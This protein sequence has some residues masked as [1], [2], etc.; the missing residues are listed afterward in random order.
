[1]LGKRIDATI[2]IVTATVGSK[3]FFYFVLALTALQGLWFALSFRPILFDEGHHINFIF[4]YRD[5][6]LPIISGQSTEWDYLGDVTRNSSYL[7]Y[8]VMSL[9]L[10]ALFFMED[11]HA[12]QII[13][14]RV[15]SLSLFLAS[16][17]LFRSALLKAGSSAASTHTALLVFV[18]IPAIAPM[19]GVVSYDVAM[20]ALF[21]LQVLWAIEIIKSGRFELA[22]LTGL[23]VLSGL[24]TVIKAA[25]IPLSIAILL[26]IIWFYLKRYGGA[27]KREF[28]DAARAMSAKF[29]ILLVIATVISVGLVVERPLMNLL[30]Y[31]KVSPNCTTVLSAD[32]CYVNY[33]SKRNQDF[34][35]AKPESFDP[36]NP[37]TFFF[38]LWVPDMIKT[39]AQQWPYRGAF[40]IMLTLLY[41]AAIAGCL[42]VIANIRSLLKNPPYQLFV[43]IVVGYIAILFMQQYN[44]YIKL[45]QPAALSGRYLM[46]VLPMMLGLVMASI[47]SFSANLR[48]LLLIGLVAALVIATQ[49]GGII[50][51]LL[52]VDRTEYY[53]QNSFSQKINDDMKQVLRPLVKEQ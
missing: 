22:R 36:I 20:M 23:V 51:H 35:A 34:I 9:P 2:K 26:Y 16:L 40:P 29:I 49:G 11:N 43:I 19:P 7:Y 6:G 15:I 5:L 46:P 37:Y 4:L 47:G 44:S 28:I 1:M 31:G 10:H 45:G 12:A 53:W 39:S 13:L 14:L 48:R 38:T 18:L 33:T 52:S 17:F 32:R 25:S 8:Y 27:I 42:L 50:T 21:A 30:E 24:L 41:S 3:K